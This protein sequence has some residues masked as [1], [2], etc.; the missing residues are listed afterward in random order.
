MPHAGRCRWGPHLSHT[1]GLSLYD[2]ERD[3]D[4]AEQVRADAVF[5]ANL[6][7]GHQ[8][9]HLCVPVTGAAGGPIPSPRPAPP[10][11]DPS[12]TPATCGCSRC[13]H[14]G[15]VCVQMA[16]YTQT[17]SHIHIHSHLDQKLQQASSYITCGEA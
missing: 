17:H 1:F 9:G 11:K 8:G 3:A 6:N 5:N 7:T 14:T 15:N 10:G 16:M 2:A 12:P 4:E 13:E